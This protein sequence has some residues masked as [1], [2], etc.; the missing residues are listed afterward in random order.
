MIKI[1]HFCRILIFLYVVV[2]GF[3]HLWHRFLQAYVFS[4]SILKRKATRS[5]FYL[6]LSSNITPLCSV[7]SRKFFAFFAWLLDGFSKSFVNIMFIVCFI[8]ECDNLLK[9]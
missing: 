2:D 1:P 7:V 5:I 4:L 9:E 3:G 6:S 8:C